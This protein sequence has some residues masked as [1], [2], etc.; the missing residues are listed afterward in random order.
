MNSTTKINL[1]KLSSE[2]QEFIRTR[3]VELNRAG[4]YPDEI[5]HQLGISLRSIYRWLGQFAAHGAVGLKTKPHPGSVSQMSDAQL[6]EL[7][8]ILLDQSP[9]QYEFEFK[10]WTLSRVQSVIKVKFGIAFSIQWVGQLLGRLGF[11]PQRPKLVALQQDVAWVKRWQTE[12]FPALKRRA[13]EEN[14]EIWFADEAA[15]RTTEAKP[16]TWALVGKTPVITDSAERGSINMIS[17]ITGNGEIEFYATERRVTS[18][19]FAAFLHKLMHGRKQKIILV[20][21]NSSIHKSN[22]TKLVVEE[23]EGRLELVY[24]PPYSPDLNPDEL[25]WAN[26]KSKTRRIAHKSAIDFKRSV[27]NIMESLREQSSLIQSFVRHC[28]G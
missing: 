3:A 14:A 18:E 4:A 20:L 17:A 1:K 8:S 13:A 6:G 26:A 19:I 15:F 22:H 16:R 27:K 24:L 10:L 12:T 2:A 9:I 5:A 21:D 28:Y 11:T 7:A 25:V 23:Y